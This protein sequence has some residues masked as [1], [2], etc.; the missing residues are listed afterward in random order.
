MSAKDQFRAPLGAS[1]P[2]PPDTTT[3]LVVKL[4]SVGSLGGLQFTR[5]ENRELQQVKS[6]AWNRG[7]LG[8]LTLAEAEAVLV[9]QLRMVLLHAEGIQAD[10]FEAL[11]P[12]RNPGDCAS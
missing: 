2:R 4:V 7:H 5:W 11:L 10:L 9:D 12:A 8:A 3:V 1:L 6:L